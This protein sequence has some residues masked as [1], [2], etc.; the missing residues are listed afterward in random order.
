MQHT[1]PVLETERA[2]YPTLESHPDHA[3]GIP[4]VLLHGAFADNET[5]RSWLPLWADAGHPAIAPLRRGR[6][7]F[8]PDK[9]RGLTFA[10]YLADTIAV[11][12][13]LDQPPILVGHSLGGLIAQKLAE[14]G[15]ASAVVLVASA[16]PAMLTAQPI[17]LP[18][19]GPQL[20]R[21]LAGRPFIVGPRACST[22]ALNEM[23]AEQRPA[24]H[25]RLTH[26]SGAVYR[27]LM[28]GSVKVDAA[29]VDV[30]VY[31][32]GGT[33]DRIVSTGLVEKTAAHYGTRAHL[34]PGRGH[35][36]VGEPGW[37]SLVAEVIAWCDRA[38]V[39]G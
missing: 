9:A 22:L 6:C 39:T 26:E 27:A 29:K 38:T 19:F 4:V 2:G 15:R 18:H 30:P 32:V 16:P 33:E 31:V 36:L 8:G 20:P 14:Q 23:P 11:L 7:G 1:S 17:A 21:I 24:V 5:F 13:T 3:T 25:A 28:A 37:E 34:L 12:D 10:D 35:W